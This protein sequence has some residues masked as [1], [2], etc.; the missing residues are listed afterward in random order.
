MP[1]SPIEYIKPTSR[2]MGRM[3]TILFRP[4]DLG[5][6]FVLG[7]TA[8][9]AALM[10]G[11]Y[12]SGGNFQVGDSGDSS[13]PESFAEFIEPAKVFVEENLGWILPLA[14]VLVLLL[15]VVSVVCLWVSS[16]GK[17]ML[18]DNVVYNR[19]LVVAPW[20]Q[21]RGVGNSLFRWRLV[22]LL[23]VSLLLVAIAGGAAI[24]LVAT[25]DEGNI[26][27]SWFVVL[28]TGI[29]ALG[30]TLL[31]AIYIAVL[32]EDFVVPLMY[33]DSLPATAAWR[34][35]IDLHNCQPGRFALYFLWKAVLGMVTAMILVMA[36]LL[37]CCV[38]GIVLAIPYLG[39]VLLLPVTVFYR[40]LGPEFLRQFGGEY[41]LWH[42]S[43]DNYGFSPRP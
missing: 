40:S 30:G 17:F 36:I 20:R 11:G 4:F 3:T 31:V 7:F 23:L 15:V 43:G 2:A 35:F 19:A 12:S 5:K 1:Y 21:Y 25:F 13:E 18:L 24:Y 38:A 34:Q 33:R 8:W 39:A 6:W 28:V 14:A 16:R 29:L 37:T 41:D 32:L 10:D 27:A 9:L 42:G 22:F 26:P